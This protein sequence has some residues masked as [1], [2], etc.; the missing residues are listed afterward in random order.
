VITQTSASKM[1]PGRLQERDPNAWYPILGILLAFGV[2]LLLF[3][4]RPVEQE[5]FLAVV[6]VSALS[7]A[8]IVTFSLR[9][10]SLSNLLASGVAVAVGILVGDVFI[11]LIPESSAAGISR[12][13]IFGGAAAGWLALYVVQLL[14][15]KLIRVKNFS[16]PSILFA[17]GLHNGVDGVIV[18]VAFLA[19]P[20]I[21]VSTTLAVLAHEIPHELANYAI[22]LAAGCT[23]KRALIL[24]VLS[25][26]PAFV[27]AALALAV[28]ERASRLSME[29]MPFIAGAFL[30]LAFGILAPN[31][32][33]S[34]HR[35]TRIVQVALGIGLM[36]LLRSLG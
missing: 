7:F 10:K 26:L 13:G 20:S 16:V 27:G 9:A 12:A 31:I 4:G 25:S 30:F 17:D 28:G 29:A 1:Q 22:L 21:G 36:W 2:L 19:G 33:A 24:N 23:K 3:K 11:H 8:G 6:C 14:I 15:P 35:S 32:L 5:T 18:A 34:G